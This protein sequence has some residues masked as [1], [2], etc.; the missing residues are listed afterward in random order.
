MKLF[1]TQSLAALLLLVCSSA[2]GQDLPLSPSRIEGGGPVD[3]E[4][5]TQRAT[6]IVR[7]IVADS[8]T[9]WIGRVIY[10]EYN[11]VVQETL[12][13]S[14]LSSITVALRGGSIGNVALA[15]P[16]TPQLATGNEIVFFGE[17]LNG[18]ASFK[19]VGIFDG[20]IPVQ[21]G[22]GLATTVAPRGRP[23]NLDDFLDEVRALGENR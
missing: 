14:A 16:G 22:V 17:S 21:Q 19:P 5:L 11:L 18:Q 4:A 7:A 9:K 3:V 8:E 1:S 2:Y 6:V 23:E 15:I 10:T 13:G 20:I 12:K